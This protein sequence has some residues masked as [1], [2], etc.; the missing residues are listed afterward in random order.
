MSSLAKPGEV[1]DAWSNTTD[2]QNVAVVIRT[3]N[4]E[5]VRLFVASG[6]RVPAHEALEDITV[7]CI[8]GRVAVAAAQERHELDTGPNCCICS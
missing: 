3:K 7:L 1:V 6:T 2:D 4:M 8:Q 5:V